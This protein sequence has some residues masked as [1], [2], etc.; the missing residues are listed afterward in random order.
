MSQNTVCPKCGGLVAPFDYVCDYC[1]NVMFNNIKTTDNINS[2]TLSFDDG[3][4]IIRQNLDALHDIPKPS[5]GKTITSALR[6]LVALYTFGIVLIFWRRP[7]KRFNKEAFDKL[8][9]IILRNI[10]FLKISSKGSGDLMLR[11][12]VF[13]DELN[14]VDK[15]VKNGILAKTLAYCLVFGLFISWFIYVVNQEPKVYSSY[16]VTAL[17]SIA[18]GNLYGHIKILP[19]T[20][21]ITHRPSGTSY[22][23]EVEVKL[24]LKKIENAG[25][26]KTK[27]NVKLMLADEKG[28]PLVGFE[29]A[30]LDNA[31]KEMFRAL[32]TNQEEKTGYFRFY[33]KNTFDHPEYIDTIPLNASRFII[34]A[35]S[36]HVKY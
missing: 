21:V 13:E 36:I 28:I 25:E 34:Q 27:F 11:I 23:W 9:Q 10:S 8:K 35:D 22:E 15:Q 2:G 19:D 18:Q 5:F 16:K 17:D 26:H 33:I 12:K 32:I 30:E 7:K 4:G 14:T 29:P 31:S 6:V 3:M 1:G 24:T 20:F